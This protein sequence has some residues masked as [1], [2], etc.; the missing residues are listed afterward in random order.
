[1][2]LTNGRFGTKDYGSKDLSDYIETNQTVT[3]LLKEFKVLLKEINYE[4]K[5]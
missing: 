2:Y 4:K 1:L 5:Y 3:P